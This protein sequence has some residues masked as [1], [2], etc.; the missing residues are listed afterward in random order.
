[1]VER[2]RKLCKEKGTNFSALEKELG[3]ANA[4]LRKTDAKIQA[5]RLKMIADYFGVSMEYILTGAE[6]PQAA[7]SGDER[8]LLQLF[9]SMPPTSRTELLSYAQYKADTQE[10]AEGKA[11]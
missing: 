7:L 9:R 3:F 4:S 8:E 2:I 6:T 1:M 11:G 10:N 5:V